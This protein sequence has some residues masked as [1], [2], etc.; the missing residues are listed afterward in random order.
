MQP[1]GGLRE[2]KKERTRRL[3]STAA[4]RLFVARGFEQ[5][6]VADV[7]ES[8]EVSEGTVFNYFRT[9]EGLVFDGMEGFYAAMLDE[10]RTRAAGES[11]LTAF[12][13][14]ML[15]QPEEPRATD[16][17]EVIA[18]SARLIA[19]SPLLLAREAEI[20]DTNAHLLANLLAR[21]TGADPADPEPLAAAQALMAVH[22]TLLFSIRRA[23][24]A[25]ERGQALTDVAANCTRRALAVVGAG[26]QDYA[27]R[28]D[29]NVGSEGADADS[30]KAVDF[31]A[32]KHHD[33]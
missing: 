23:A 11:A 25:G 18:E 4:W 10:I 5:V 19:A 7:A 21:E 1:T 28:A 30:T 6:T 8:A 31:H 27:I 3:I 15:R 29:R 14:F 24:V 16:V 9:K 13:R 32:T 33:H 22:R 26:L 20:V 2:R 12:G 17:G